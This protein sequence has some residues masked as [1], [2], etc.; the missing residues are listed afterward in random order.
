MGECTMNVG[1]HSNFGT[2]RQSRHLKTSLRLAII[3]G[4]PF[5]PTYDP[6]ENCNKLSRLFIFGE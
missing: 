6:Y 2:F 5:N 1:F 4:I 3:N